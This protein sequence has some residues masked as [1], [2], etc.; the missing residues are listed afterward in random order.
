[1]MNWLFMRL[2]LSWKRKLVTKLVHIA[3]DAGAETLA[4]T[5]RQKFYDDFREVIR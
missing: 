5:M 1:M 3:D 2:P 4:A